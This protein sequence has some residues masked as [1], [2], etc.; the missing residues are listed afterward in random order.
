MT[1]KVVTGSQV[2][3]ILLSELEKS[4]KKPALLMSS[5]LDSTSLLFALLELGKSPTIYTFRLDGVYSQDFRYAKK[6]AD[7]FGIPFV[8]VVLPV[9]IDILLRDLVNLIRNLGL[10]KKADIECTWPMLYAINEMREDIIYTGSCADGHF[11]ISKKAVLHYSQTVE[12]LD[13]FRLGLFTNP[14][15]AQVKTLELY[16]R[17]V[18][19][20]I[21]APY[22]A[23]EMVNLFLGSSWESINKPKQKQPIRDTYP[24]EF[25]RIRTF[26]H[27]NLQLGD[28]G[29]ANHF[30]KLM[31][32]PEVNIRNKKSPVAVYN[33]IAKRRILNNG[34]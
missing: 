34:R 10:R 1:D 24:E 12:K 25:S 14:D 19:K 20:E 16:C 31:A 29:I 27:T 22:R 15:Y 8:D 30:T 21:F 32:I 23:S 5:G 17:S 7:L 33:D 18:G 28:S 13:K 4:P 11:G 3:K 6:T 26:N 9:D 2:R